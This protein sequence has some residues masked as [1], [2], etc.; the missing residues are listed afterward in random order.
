MKSISV[1]IVSCF[2][3]TKILE[4][5][6][7]NNY[8]DGLIKHLN[9]KQPRQ[10]VFILENELDIDDPVMNSLMTA[11]NMNFPSLIMTYDIIN[12]QSRKELDY[13]FKLGDSTMFVLQN[14]TNKCEDILVKIPYIFKPRILIINSCLSSQ[15][16]LNNKLQLQWWKKSLDISVLSHNQQWKVM[17]NESHKH[18]V[19]FISQISRCAKTV[20]FENLSS[21][22][23]WFRNSC[24]HNFKLKNIVK[25]TLSSKVLEK[26]DFLRRLVTILG[27]NNYKFVIPKTFK[28]SN[29]LI[30]SE[31]FGNLLLGTIGMIGIIR[32]AA[33]YMKFERNTWQILNISQIIIGMPTAREPR[34]FS[35][36]LVYGSLLIT[37]I[38]Y[39]SY[40]YSVILDITC[41]LNSNIITLEELANSSLKIIGSFEKTI[42]LE[43]LSHHNPNIAKIVKKIEY[44]PNKE[45][46]YND[47][48]MR[49]LIEHQ[50]ISCLFLNAE[51][52]VNE[53]CGKNEVNVKIVDEIIYQDINAIFTSLFCPKTRPGTR[54]SKLLRYAIEFGLL[55][56]LFPSNVRN[57]NIL[58]PENTE[59]EKLFFVLFRVL[60]IG[61]SLS[62]I[63]FLI[64]ISTAIFGRRMYALYTRFRFAN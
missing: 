36:R 17:L 9:E 58:L 38:V 34:K 40:F 63:S 29:D 30:L 5:S 51:N 2:L 41:P 31:E 55:K 13:Y 56:D 6:S 42:S 37:C 39:S 44:S 3:W 26:N 24:N 19:P 49:Y 8:Y 52:V 11:I 15:N 59:K 64:E 7:T 47:Y 4:I 23:Q 28:H 25:S 46:E 43:L 48:C 27:F 50:N 1:Y 18:E 57:T 61:Y 33:F 62:L 60:A 32:L 12:R 35:E 10:V 21:E 14:K 54:Q 22:S 20:F 45:E 53:Y 16:D